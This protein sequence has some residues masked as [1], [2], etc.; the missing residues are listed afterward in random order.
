MRRAFFAIL[1][2][3][4]TCGCGQSG[5]TLRSPVQP[6][7]AAPVPPSPAPSPV[8][9]QATLAVSSFVLEFQETYLGEYYYRPQLTLSET[10]GHSGATLTW[11]TFFADGFSTFIAGPGC[12][13]KNGSD[14]VS[15]GGTWQIDSVYYYCLDIASRSDFN[16]KAPVVEIGFQ[17]DAGV[18]GSVTA[19]GTVR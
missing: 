12:F 13:L 17:D 7:P 14:R 18:P 1:S 6:F 2:V 4:F 3:L 15:A 11:I 19:T 8:R 9:T 10:G 5:S 16:G